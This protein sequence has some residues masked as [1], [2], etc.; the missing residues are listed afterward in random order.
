[1][2]NSESS[3]CGRVKRPE[4]T[5]AKRHYSH[6]PNPTAACAVPLETHEGRSPTP[7]SAPRP[8]V[9]RTKSMSSEGEPRLATRHDPPPIEP[10]ECRGPP[11]PGERGCPPQSLFLFLS[12]FLDRKGLGDGRHVSQ[13][14]SIAIARRPHSP[15]RPATFSPAAEVHEIRGLAPTCYTTCP[16]SSPGPG[17]EA[18]TSPIP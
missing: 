12:P 15:E 10:G 14:A 5:P 6:P 13:S 8:L 2:R 4:Y 1:M 3:L 9:L 11:L 16:Q 17:C 18:T 7:R